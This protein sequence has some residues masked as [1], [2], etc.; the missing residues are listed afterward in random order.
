[1]KQ[2]GI[3]L[4]IVT[5][6]VVGSFGLWSWVVQPTIAEWREATEHE[7]TLKDKLQRYQ[8]LVNKAPE[9][10]AERAKIAGNMNAVPSDEPT[11]AG[12]AQNAAGDA[13]AGFLSHL[14]SLTDAAGFQAS[15]LHYVRAEPFDAYSELRFEMKAKAPLAKIHDFLVKMTASDYYLRVQSLAI[16]PQ[17][18]N[19]VEA[20]MSLVALANADAVEAPETPKRGGRPK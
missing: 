6:A 3:V 19:E 20:D 17:S 9:L 18:G 10:R 4:S 16:T 11:S 15:N 5:A 1:V 13:I 7:D 2:S 8:A 12:D 14:K